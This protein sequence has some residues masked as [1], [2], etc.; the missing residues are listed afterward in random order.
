MVSLPVEV[1]LLQPISEA[2]GPRPESVGRTLHTSAQEW[3][4]RRTG[5]SMAGSQA[6]WE[7]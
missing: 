3:P 1:L 7:S 6:W 5:R 2:R 4:G